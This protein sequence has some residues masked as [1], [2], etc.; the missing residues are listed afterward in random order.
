[1]IRGSNGNF[2]K[3]TPWCFKNQHFGGVPPSP[4]HQLGVNFLL[5][6]PMNFSKLLQKIMFAPNFW[7][8]AISGVQIGLHIK[9]KLF[10]NVFWRP[11]SRLFIVRGSMSYHDGHLNRSNFLRKFSNNH[12]YVTVLQHVAEPCWCCALCRSHVP[13]LLV[14]RSTYHGLRTLPLSHRVLQENRWDPP[15]LILYLYSCT[16]FQANNSATI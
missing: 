12:L 16:Y 2:S 8:V 15:H 9:I 3:L 5:F 6:W 13:H 4:P 14:D 11:G 10:K 1:M 7:T